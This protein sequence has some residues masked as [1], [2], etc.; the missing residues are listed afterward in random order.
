MCQDC[1]ASWTMPALA[2]RVKKAPTVTPT[3]SLGITYVPV[4]LDTWELPVTRISTSAYW[5]KVSPTNLQT[6]LLFYALKSDWL[7]TLSQESF[8]TIIASHRITSILRSLWFLK[9]HF[10]VLVIAVKKAPK[11]VVNSLVWPPE[12]T[13]TL[14]KLSLSNLLK[15]KM[16]LVQN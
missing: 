2:T 10:T 7:E 3:P 5:V 14:P 12:T 15:I 9:Y 4:H 11:G 16:L 6:V 8:I 1:C 13:Q